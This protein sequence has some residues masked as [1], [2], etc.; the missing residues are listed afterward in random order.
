[1]MVLDKLLPKLYEEG[2]RVLVFCQMTRML[3]ILEDYCI[4]KEF[5]YFRLDGQTPHTD[6][7]VGYNW[8]IICWVYMYTYTNSCL[9]IDGTDKVLDAVCLLI[10][11]VHVQWVQT[12]NALQM[13]YIPGIFVV[14]IND[15]LRHFVTCTYLLIIFP[16]PSS[17]L[18]HSNSLTPTTDPTAKSFSSCCPHEQGGW[19]ST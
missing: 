17:P 6:R 10:L 14:Q 4:W 11:H 15:S 13:S 9:A 3:D 8:D 12:C 5:P 2:S 7:Q 18:L 19:E 16:V 1:M